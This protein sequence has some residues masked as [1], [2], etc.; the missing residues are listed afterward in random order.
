MIQGSQYFRAL[1][2]SLPY[3]LLRESENLEGK[4]KKSSYVSFKFSSAWT[5]YDKQITEA[6]IKM[7]QEP[8]RAELHPPLRTFLWNE[9]NVTTI[10]IFFWHSTVCKV[11]FWNVLHIHTALLRCP[12]QKRKDGDKFRDSTDANIRRKVG[13]W[14]HAHM[15]EE[16]RE[17]SPPQ[18]AS[19]QDTLSTLCHSPMHPQVGKK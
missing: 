19:G 2:K 11:S 14:S 1:L 3:R 7:L 10:L 16:K 17:C 5:W 13:M 8:D 15:E 4:K 18:P 6:C 9:K 12:G